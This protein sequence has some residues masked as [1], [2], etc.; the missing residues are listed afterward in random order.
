MILHV[1]SHIQLNDQTNFELFWEVPY[2]YYVKTHLTFVNCV[3]LLSM[4]NSTGMTNQKNHFK[5]MSLPGDNRTVI[6]GVF[7]E[8][9][10]WDVH[11]WKRRKD[12]EMEMWSEEKGKVK[13]TGEREGESGGTAEVDTNEEP[14]WWDLTEEKKAQSPDTDAPQHSLA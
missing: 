2:C 5:R 10:K 8:D 13:E 14:L 9:C 4:W 12:I 1:E 11:K 3:K 6:S 7:W